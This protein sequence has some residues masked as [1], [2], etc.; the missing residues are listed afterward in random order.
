M[1]YVQYKYFLLTQ[2]WEFFQQFLEFFRFF[3]ILRLHSI[4]KPRNA[5]MYIFHN[6][7]VIFSLE[8]CSEIYTIRILEVNFLTRKRGSIYKGSTS[9]S[10]IIILFERN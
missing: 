8:R 9:I 4:H 1:D 7:N 3:Y 6:S 10:A 5:Y 2:P